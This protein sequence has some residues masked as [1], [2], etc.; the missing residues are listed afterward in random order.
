MTETEL[1]EK[2]D[3]IR[4]MLCYYWDECGDFE[5]WCDWETNQ[6]LIKEHFPEVLIVLKNYKESFKAMENVIEGL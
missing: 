2:L 5:I 6:A 4:N 1:E 3:N